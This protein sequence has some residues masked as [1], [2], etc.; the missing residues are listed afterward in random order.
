MP[1]QITFKPG[2]IEEFLRIEADQETMTVDNIKNKAMREAENFI[3]HDFS[4]KTITWDGVAVVTPVEADLSVKT[5]VLDRMLDLY[6]N[7]GSASQPDFSTLKP[8]RVF[9][10]RVREL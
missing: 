1:L 3:N 7:R 8:F 5:W 4:L 10:M 2:E 9:P 6:E